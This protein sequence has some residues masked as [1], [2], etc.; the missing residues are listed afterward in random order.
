MDIKVGDRIRAIRD[1]CV[2]T[3]EEGTVVG[4]PDSMGG[5][6]NNRLVRWDNEQILLGFQLA[7]VEVIRD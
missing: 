1:T 5:C 6:S 3:G 2:D 7:D 4:L